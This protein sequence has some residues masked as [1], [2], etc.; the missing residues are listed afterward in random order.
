MSNDITGS[1]RKNGNKTDIRG[2]DTLDLPF[3]FARVM[4][5]PL[6]V[7]VDNEKRIRTTWLPLS[8]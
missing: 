4:D 8:R 3:C 6:T 5:M 1:T 7:S 2:L